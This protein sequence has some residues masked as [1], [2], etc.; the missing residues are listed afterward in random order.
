MVEIP[1][2]FPAAK[3]D[4]LQQAGVGTK[5]SAQPL[6][7]PGEGCSER[8]V[9]H[10]SYA[11]GVQISATEIA[12]THNGQVVAMHPK[13]RLDWDDLEDEQEHQRGMRRWKAECAAKPPEEMPAAPTKTNRWRELI[14]A[15]FEADSRYVEY[16]S[17]R[18]RGRRV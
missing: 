17:S 9:V 3:V 1:I 14:E 4:D 7:R 10:H 16:T 12:I 13:L 2:Y 18:P 8:F 6:P 5:F 11:N 15:I